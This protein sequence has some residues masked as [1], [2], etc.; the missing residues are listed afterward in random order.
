VYILRASAAQSLKRF[1]E[2]LDDLGKAA[3]INPQNPSI[4]AQRGLVWTE[5]EKPD[6]AIND[7]TQAIALDSLNSFALFNRALILAKRNEN[8]PALLD[9]NRVI[10]ISPYNS[11]AYY[12]RAIV[13]IGMNRK[14]AAIRD[15]ETVS[16][17][18]PKNI[19]SY[20]YRSR[21]RGELGDYEGALADL[22][23]A[24]ELLPDY[25]DAWFDRSE[26][27][28]KLNDRKGAQADYQQA[29][30]LV[31]QNRLDPDSLRAGS[32]D[33]LKSLVRLS[34]DF[35]EMNAMSSKIQNQAVDIRLKPMF[36]I[37]IWKA[38]FGKTRL[39]D[40]Y[41]KSNY[42][43]TILWLT[44]ETGLISDSTLRREIEMQSHRIDSAGPVPD[45][46]YR[47]AVTWYHLRRYDQSYRDLNTV[48]G[49]DS[50]SI[51]GW[52]C[53]AGAGYEKMMQMAELEEQRQEVTISTMPPRSVDEEGPSVLEHTY[54]SVIRDYDRAL[55]L[56]PAFAF[57]WYNRGYIHTRMGNYREAVDDF[58]QAIRLRDD[59]AEA[60]YNRGLLYI[61]LSENHNG[62]RDLSRAGELGITD[63]YR[64]MKRYCYK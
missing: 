17:L 16:K 4:Y 24:I 9:L 57:G 51:T 14:E 25:T 56:D 21:L 43:V 18:D 33:Y 59:L 38:D 49:A 15:F 29:Q 50:S 10:A 12:N 3:G 20:Y 1:N 32:R 37:L 28:L 36:S 53:R 47:R 5:L 48:L 35:E 64:V 41:Q 55:K 58:S 34:G 7:F 39:Y 6:S 26:I 22:D 54:E 40:V 46:F 61:L 19:I 2:A 8:E 31:K 27:K 30:A 44:N 60:W 42:P 62:C 63:A 52:F 23:R 11:Y 13:L 45:A